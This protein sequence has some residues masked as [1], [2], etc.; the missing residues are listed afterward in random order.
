MRLLT[1]SLLLLPLASPAPEEEPPLLQG[2]FQLRGRS[3]TYEFN[4][5]ER[6]GN[7]RG[8]RARRSPPARASKVEVTLFDE[9]ASQGSGGLKITLVEGERTDRSKRSSLGRS[10]RFRRSFFNK[11]NSAEQVET[12]P[13]YSREEPDNSGKLRTGGLLDILPYVLR[14]FNFIRVLIAIISGIFTLLG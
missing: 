3:Y 11:Q 10:E 14:V 13:D 5:L 2:A 9:E 7:E 1:L 6:D 4:H 12:E 8:G